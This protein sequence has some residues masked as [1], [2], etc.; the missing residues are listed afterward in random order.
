MYWRLVGFCGS[1]AMGSNY[2]MILQKRNSV[3]TEY[4]DIA[5]A[6]RGK[7]LAPREFMGK[8]AQMSRLEVK[9]QPHL[10]RSYSDDT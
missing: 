9:E 8:T 1:W 6:G 3:I 7:R 2:F 10:R 4:N 5:S